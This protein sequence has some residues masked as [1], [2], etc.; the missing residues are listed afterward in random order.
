MIELVRYIVS[1]LVDN[2]DKIVIAQN[3]EIIKVTVDKQDMG[4]II[5]RQGTIARS[6]K[7]IVRSAANKQNLKV[8]VEIVDEL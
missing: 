8:Q 5:G 6:I 1:N 3:G 2:P 4:K 7:T